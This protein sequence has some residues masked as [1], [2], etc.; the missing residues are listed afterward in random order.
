MRE[1]VPLLGSKLLPPAPNPF[2]L[3][4]P[5]LHAELRDALER[6]VTAVVAGPGYGKTSLV[7]RFLRDAAGADSVWLTLDGSDRDPWLLFQYLVRGLRE[8]APE[9]GART[10]ALWESLRQR[11]RAVEALCD[12]FIG[13]AEE[14]LGGRFVLVL[15]E[16]EALDGSETCARA[17]RRLLAYLPGTLHLILVGRSLPES[18][19]KAMLAE[20]TAGLLR[21]EDLLF[22]REE[23]GDLLRQIFHLPVTDETVSKVHTRTRGW[24]T[25]LQLLRQTARLE[26]ATPDLPEEVFVRTEAEIFEYFGEEVLA[27][28]SKAVREFLMVSSLPGLLDPEIVAEVRGDLDVPKRLADVL[29]RKLFLSPLESRGAYYV[30]DPLFRDYLRRKLRADAGPAV[31]RSLHGSYGKAFAAR[32]DLPQALAHFRSSE[33]PGEV[34]DLLAKHG[35]SL[36]RAGALDTVRESAEY[37]AARGIHSAALEDLLG[38][39]CRVSGDYAAAVGHFERALAGGPRGPGKFPRRARASALQGLAYSLLKT[40]DVRRAGETAERAL[41]EAPEDDPPLRARILNTL[42]I[43]RYRENRLPEAVTGWQEALARARQGGDEHLVLMIAHNLGLPHAAMGDFRRASEYFGMLTGPDNL[44]LGPEEGAAYLNLARIETLRGHYS[45]SAALLGDAREIA[46]KLRLRALSADVLEAEGTLLRESGDLPGARS[47]YARARALF[48]ELGQ[49]ELL[50]GLAEEEA[51]LCARLGET[52]EAE[53]TAQSLAAKRRKQGDPEGIA[54]SLLA[55]GEI[56]LLAENAS[57]AVEPLSESARL[58]KTL[59]RSYQDCRAHLLLALACHR[60]GKTDRAEAAA[61]EALRLAARFDYRPAVERVTALEDGFRRWLVT[62]PGAPD[63]L[64]VPEAAP[65]GDALRIGAAAPGSADLT[66]RLLGPIEVYRDEARKIPARAWKLRRALEIFCFLASSRDRRATKDRIVDALWGDARLSVIEKNFHPTISFLRGALNHEHNVP[67]NFI[68]FERGAYLLNPAYRYDIDLEAFE[69]GLRAA[70]QR[71]SKG[72]DAAARSAFEQALALYRGEFL[73]E[74]YGE[75]AEAPRASYA[76]LYLQALEEAGRL[77]LKAGSREAGLALLE[78][79]VQHDP[80][81]EKASIELMQALGEAGN[82]AGVEKEYGRLSRSLAD[83]VESE[84]LAE[85]R[86]AYEKARTMEV[87]P[88]VPASAKIIPL[89]KR[90]KTSSS[91]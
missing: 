70:R 40:G 20:G 79:R 66:V 8:H 1:S 13:E 91:S 54:S 53:D 48:T 86:R 24:A 58:F 23:T 12:V 47:R 87:P 85:T 57:S 62:L 51:I 35:K 89:R 26:K 29:K 34:E 78:K 74:E 60:C 15:D 50:D 9:F 46:Q 73:E 16:I 21:G 82:R 4:R 25:A 63:W 81:N 5:R 77:H 28:E 49:I 10:E 59:E 22:T 43:V 30:F 61:R 42:S 88:S 6:R 67:K 90:G 56:H 19:I 2:H 7:A 75:W 37:L 45:Q 64:K 32:G 71:L 84:P 83:E 17:L 31:E 14:S 3:V 65:P 68:L 41:E 69:A 36:L 52:R 39:A 44:R 76:A 18:G 38:E 55:L 11:P 27:S 33:S 72:D 80:L